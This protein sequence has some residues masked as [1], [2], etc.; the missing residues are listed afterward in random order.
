MINVFIAYSRED[1]R[2][3]TKII[4]HLSVLKRNRK[5]QNWH[6]GLIQPGTR[7]EDQITSNLENAKIILLLISVDFL[8]SDYCYEKEMQIAL[9][10]H[11]QKQAIVI[12]IIVR[13]CD[14]KDSPIGKLQAIPKDG[15]PLSSNVWSPEDEGYLDATN[16]LKAVIEKAIK[17][18]SIKYKDKELKLDNI[19]EEKE[20]QLNNSILK[21]LNN[22]ILKNRQLEDVV[23]SL[24]RSHTDFRRDNQLLKDKIGEYESLLSQRSKQNSNHDQFFRNAANP[25]VYKTSFERIFEEGKK[26]TQLI[27]NIEN[28]ISDSSKFELIDKVGESQSYQLNT[29]LLKLRKSTKK[30]KD[31][32]Q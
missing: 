24:K 4:K 6:D 29:L 27:D 26:I 25:Q 11:K 18:D 14:W 20:T 31:I 7:W 19:L 5:I 22:Y 32:S 3:K 2:Y 16:R 15:I 9:N 21:E 10:R 17:N 8:A 28:L 12:P 1:E 23:A 30:I 13:P